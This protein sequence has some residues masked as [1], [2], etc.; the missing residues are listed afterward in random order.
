MEDIY[1]DIAKDVEL[2][3]DSPEYEIKK[4]YLKKKR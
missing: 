4:H 2:R 3:F 1:L